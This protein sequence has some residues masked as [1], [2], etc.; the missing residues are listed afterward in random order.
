MSGQDHEQ[1]TEKL[2]KYIYVIKYKKGSEMAADFLSKNTIDAL[3]IF[4][5]LPFTLNL[6]TP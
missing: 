6:S 2:L 3:G 4:V 1:V 5:T